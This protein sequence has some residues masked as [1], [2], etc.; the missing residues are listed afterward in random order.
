[1][2]IRE[3]LVVGVVV[4][5]VVEVDLAQRSLLQEMLRMLL[6]GEVE[7][8]D[9]VVIVVGVI[10][11]DVAVEEGIQVDTILTAHMDVGQ[12]QAEVGVVL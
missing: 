8:Q 11:M 2:R 4:H 5:A 3:I 6:R 12:A 9:N 7:P 10:V 1:V